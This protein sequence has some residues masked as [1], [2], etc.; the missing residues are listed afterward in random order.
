VAVVQIWPVLTGFSI[1]IGIKSSL[2]GPRLAVV[3]RWPLFRG[4]C[5]SEVAVNTG[6]TVYE[7][8]WLL[9]SFGVCHQFP[10][11]PK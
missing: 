7:N 10:S 9:L 2:A 11:V 6:L 3:D 5:Y 4:G 8:N 1:K